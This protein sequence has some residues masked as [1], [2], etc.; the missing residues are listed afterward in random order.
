M[1]AANVPTELEQALSCP[2]DWRSIP[3][4]RDLETAIFALELGWLQSFAK[5]AVDEREVWLLEALIKEKRTAYDYSEGEEKPILKN[6]RLR[7][8]QAKTDYLRTI[9]R[10]ASVQFLDPAADQRHKHFEPSL[11]R[12]QAVQRSRS[13]DSLFFTNPGMAGIRVWFWHWFSRVFELDS[14]RDQSDGPRFRSAGDVVG[15]SSLAD[16]V[17]S[18]FRSPNERVRVLCPIFMPSVGASNGAEVDHI[19]LDIYLHGG[20]GTIHSYPALADAA[21]NNI[22]RLGYIDG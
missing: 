13:G 11:T 10:F 8:D 14:D 17:W 6:V 7:Y 3:V 16:L 5:Y 4:V 20:G 18:A 9:G 22:H 19:I 12:G 21:G 1:L 15:E 2:V